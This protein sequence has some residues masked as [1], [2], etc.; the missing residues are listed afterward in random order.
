MEVVE[1]SGDDHLVDPSLSEDIGRALNSTLL[2][3]KYYEQNGL[4][5]AVD[6]VFR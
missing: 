2:I 1:G 6:D 4:Y 3:V 5:L